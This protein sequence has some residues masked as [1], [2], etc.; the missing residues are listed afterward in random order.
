MIIDKITLIIV[1]DNYGYNP[2]FRTGFGFSCL[3]KIDNKKILFDTGGD[4]ETLLFNLKK[5]GVTSGD[6][7]TIVISHMHGDHTGGLDGILK[8]NKDVKVYMP[9]SIKPI[10]VTEGIYTTEVLGTWLKEQ[11]LVV[12]TKKGPVLITGCAHPGIVK[13]IKKAKELFNEEV[14]LVLGGF[15]L[16]GASDFQLLGI[17]KSFKELGVQKAAPCHCSGDRCRELFKE[18]YGDDYIEVGVGKVINL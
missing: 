14:Y 16:G 7:D 4:S 3:V 5:V 2:D 11:G 9:E 8:E 6:I 18:Q 10:K 15:H 1:Y 12:E 13:I 17:I